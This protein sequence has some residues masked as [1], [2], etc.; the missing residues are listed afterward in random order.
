MS[1]EDELVAKVPDAILDTICREDERIYLTGFTSLPLPDRRI[2][3]PGSN[4]QSGHS[5]SP[6]ALSGRHDHPI[7]L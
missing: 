1:S 3:K 7:G 2:D 6:L 4:R 5:R